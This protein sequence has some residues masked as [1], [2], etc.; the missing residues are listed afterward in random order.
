MEKILSIKDVARR[1]GRNEATVSRWIRQGWYPGRG[2]DPVI[3]YAE[4]CG[5]HWKI[6][7]AAYVAFKAA[8]KAASIIEDLPDPK[9]KRRRPKEKSRERRL[10][11]NRKQLE[12]MGY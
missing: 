7:E 10:E 11:E 4:R 1:E 12:A 9:P 3:L 2:A 8:C 6:T 5:K